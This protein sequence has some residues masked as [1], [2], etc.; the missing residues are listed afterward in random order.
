MRGLFRS[1]ANDVK[2]A[3]ARVCYDPT[4]AAV[5]GLRIETTTFALTP[6]LI[7]EDDPA[8][9]Q[10]LSRLLGDIEPGAEIEC[11]ADLAQ[12]RACLARR[13]FAFVLVD[14]G[15]P[16]GDGGDLIVELQA[17]HPRPNV[18]VI[19]AWGHEE[20]V[21]SALRAGADGY[22]L[23]ERDDLELMVSLR[24]VQRGGAPIDPQLARRILALVPET[25][26]AVVDA[27][28]IRLSEREIEVL[29]LI[30]RGC[31]NRE[32][33]ELTSLSRLTIEGYTKAIYRKLA[34]GSR[35]AAVYEAKNLGLL[36]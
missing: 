29:T 22:L 23:K 27:A 14:I 26:A 12:A 17:L 15:L 4:A 3:G 34:V 31:S 9:R 8:M 28:P 25:G 35:A 16:D 11:A 33:A 10:R 13:R 2:P 1:G 19:S 24:S 20:L 5:G 30:A 32:I 36:S 18:L 6:A 21:L 7:V